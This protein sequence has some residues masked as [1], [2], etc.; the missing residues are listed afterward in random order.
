MEVSGLAVFDK[1]V[2]LFGSEGAARV[3]SSDRSC[4]EETCAGGAGM[5]TAVVESVDP[6]ILGMKL[7]EV[8]SCRPSDCSCAEIPAAVAACF[9]ESLVANGDVN[10]LF[11]TLGQFSIIRLERDTQLM[12]PVYDY[13]MPEKECTCDGGCGCQEDPCDLFR[14]VQFPVGEFFPPNCIADRRESYQ[15][16]KTCG[17]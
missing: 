16:F 15:E 3:F 4:E 8:C 10:R 6:L 1:R 9:G 14:K 13:C 11:V 2:V 12:I 7:V 5:P 17:C